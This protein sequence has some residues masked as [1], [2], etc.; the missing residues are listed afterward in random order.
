MAKNSEL[1]IKV[2]LLNN[3]KYFAK[4]MYLNTKEIKKENYYEL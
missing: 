4:I 2:W 3:L 1:Q